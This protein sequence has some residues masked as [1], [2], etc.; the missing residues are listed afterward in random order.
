[1]THPEQEFHVIDKRADEKQSSRSRIRRGAG[2]SSASNSK[3]S[4]AEPKPSQR[5]RK[6]NG[7]ISAAQPCP[8]QIRLAHW[9]ASRLNDW[10]TDG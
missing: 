9:P 2:S 7:R 1:M 10:L 6:A 3:D 5:S 8:W 4:P